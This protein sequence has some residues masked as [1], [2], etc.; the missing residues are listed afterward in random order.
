MT[1]CRVQIRTPVPL[2]ELSLKLW[3]CIEPCLSFQVPFACAVTRMGFSLQLR[4][5]LIVIEMRRPIFSTAGTNWRRPDS[6]SE[7]STIRTQPQT[8]FEF[9]QSCLIKNFY[10]R[11]SNIEI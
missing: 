3:L 8:A 2:S 9:H 6:K 7:D 10:L 4:G 11:S 5:Y 1:S